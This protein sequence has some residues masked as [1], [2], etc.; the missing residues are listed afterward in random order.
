MG[1]PVNVI[2][3]L[4]AARTRRDHQA[5]AKAIG[6]VRLPLAAFAGGS[7]IFS[8]GSTADELRC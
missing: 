4:S 3:R 1:F 6:G 5:R 2:A 7:F 8:G